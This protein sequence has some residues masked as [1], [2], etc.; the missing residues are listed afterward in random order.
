LRYDADVPEAV[1]SWRPTDLPDVVRQSVAANGIGFL[2]PGPRLAKAVAAG[3]M[4][5]D[6]IDATLDETGSRFLGRLLAARLTAREGAP[7]EA[8]PPVPVDP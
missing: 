1:R 5:Y 4:V 7:D 3:T 2:N 6:P 8:P